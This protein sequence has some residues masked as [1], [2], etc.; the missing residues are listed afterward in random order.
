M[1]LKILPVEYIFTIIIITVPHNDENFDD[2]SRIKI[3][4][5]TFAHGY[6]RVSL[7][8]TCL[9]NNFLITY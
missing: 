4:F 2:F 7:I 8:F 9:N 6:L 5:N 1:H 3:Q